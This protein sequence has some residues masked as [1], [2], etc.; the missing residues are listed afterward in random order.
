MKLLVALAICSVVSFPAAAMD[1]EVSGITNKSGHKLNIVR[2]KGAI[3]NREVRRWSHATSL[4]DP[5]FDTLFV[6]NSP[7]GNVPIG[8]F[9]IKQI[10]EFLSQQAQNGRTSWIVIEGQCSSMCVPMFFTWPN[11]FA[12]TD[13]KI[14]LH[15]VSDGGLG[16]DS[17]LTKAYL[18]NMRE[19]ARERGETTALTWIEKMVAR[20][21]FSSFRLT[22]YPAQDIAKDQGLLA[23]EGIVGSVDQ[24]IERL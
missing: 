3:D 13:T 20:G 14:G 17:D 18:D 21:E 19:R 7:G 11:R 5:D 12:V 2:M 24:L 9:T 10:G 4:L 23:P 15:G 6:M 16:D 1:F 8:L 22:P